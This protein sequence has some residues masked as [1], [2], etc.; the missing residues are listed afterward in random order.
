MFPRSR[1]S[2]R[3]VRAARPR[4]QFVDEVPSRTEPAGRQSYRPLLVTA[5][6]FAA[7]VL[8]GTGAILAIRSDASAMTGTTAPTTT[9]VV[10]P[11]PITAAAAPPAALPPEQA[12]RF[13]RSSRHRRR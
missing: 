10:R 1:P 6:I 12:P 8:V 3:A 13:R 2:S 5:G 7:M 4:V 9:T 11:D